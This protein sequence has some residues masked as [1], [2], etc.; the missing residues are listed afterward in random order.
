[1]NYGF[2]SYAYYITYNVFS[3]LMELQIVFLQ[4]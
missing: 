2:V 1:M 4:V 3:K